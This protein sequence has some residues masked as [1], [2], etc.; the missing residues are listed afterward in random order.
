MVATLVRLRWR[1]TLNALS[2][3]VWI[4]LA[5]LL[6]AA[7]ALGTIISV[8]AGAVA[9]GLRAPV[10]LT[11]T[12]I[13]A[14]GALTT[15]GWV[16]VPLLLTGVDS[17]LDPRALAPWIAPSRSLSAG[18]AVAGAAGV[19]GLATGVCLA[20]P[21]LAW[22]AGGHWGAAGLALL[23]A[24]V[25]LATCVLVSRV[26]VIGLGASTTRRGRDLVGVIGGLAL[27]GVALLPSLLNLVAA[28]SAGLGG[29]ALMTLMRLGRV[30]SLS[31]FGWA[32]AA[33]GYLAQ[34]RAGA[35][36]ALAVG[37]LALPVA[38]APLWNR[39]VRRV[40]SGGRA[41]GRRSRPERAAALGR[42]RAAA[43]D[44]DAADAATAAPL[45]WHRRLSRLIPSPAAAIAARC[46]RY[47]RTD[48]R[49]LVLGVSTVLVMLVVGVVTVLGFRQG[50]EENVAF[51]TAP[52]GAA[53]GR[54][55]AALLGVPVAIA[56]M[57]GWVLHDDLGYDSTAQ[58]MHLSAGVRGL[59]DRL[60]RVVAAALWQL[61]V[62]A[63]VTLTLG[64]WTGRWEIV[65]AVV[66]AQLGLY[67]AAAAWS[68]VM[69]AVLPYEVNAPGES[70]LRS[71]S[72]GMILVA[73]LVQMAGMAVIAGL[74]LPV[75][76]GLGALMATGAWQWG[77]A[78]LAGG[79]LWGAGLARA[80]V[81]VGGR[82]LD[83]HWVRVLAVVR[84][85]PGHAETR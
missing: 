12:L 66:G 11:A 18:L 7:W 58:W 15:L 64:V 57:S 84:T 33:P 47:W 10:P 60:G 26:V 46:L 77:W 34:G 6:G 28:R 43:D 51:E 36:L 48:P 31:P 67:G 69:S 78:L 62:L 20:L 68:S 52:A 14:L 54:A 44:A 80:G 81:V 72:S 37:A 56:L 76:V 25:A 24:P 63:V 1:L 49:Y 9:L 61:P 73:S 83:R 16:L 71:R 23:L 5:S 3:S 79:A 22:A 17:T 45:P 21:A 13:G 85:W 75:A 27:I 50:A 65:P 2:R 59:D 55:P 32:F 30:L 82:V 29:S 40:M 74:A 35:A 19:P 42:T 4:L 53:L 39:I 8:A 70:P 41:A 38:L